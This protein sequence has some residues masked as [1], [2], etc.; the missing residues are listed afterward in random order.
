[1]NWKYLQNEKISVPG[2][3]RGEQERQTNSGNPKHA[4][5]LARQKK[6][7]RMEA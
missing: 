6:Q 5:K 3:R 4:P 1:M 2:R 7:N